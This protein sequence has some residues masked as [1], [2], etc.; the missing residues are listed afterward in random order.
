MVRHVWLLA[1]ITVGIIWA[2]ALEWN[3][4]SVV[5]LQIVVDFSGIASVAKWK[6]RWK[7]K[8]SARI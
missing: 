7:A 5:V 1:F 4:A 2:V 6:I 8:L 3:K